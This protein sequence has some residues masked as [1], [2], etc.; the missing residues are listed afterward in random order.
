MGGEQ[1]ATLQIEVYKFVDACKLVA[2]SVPQDKVAELVEILK[3]RLY[4]D[5]YQLV[6]L[7]TFKAVEELLVL[8]KSTYLRTRTL[9][10]VMR[11][12]Y[13]ASQR[14]DEDVCQFA[15]RRGTTHGTNPLP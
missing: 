11:E 1:S 2:R 14:A 13:E 4:G 10:S 5:A 15:R 6:R 8:I 9:D 3:Q 7:R 12:L